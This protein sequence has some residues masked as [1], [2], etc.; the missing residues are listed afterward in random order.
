MMEK[1]T[2]RHT[3][4][5]YDLSLEEYLARGPWMG[6]TQWARAVVYPDPLELLTDLGVTDLRSDEVKVAGAYTPE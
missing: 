6:F 1:S 5:E 4:K 2:P 3:W